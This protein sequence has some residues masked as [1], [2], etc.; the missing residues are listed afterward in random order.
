MRSVH[1]NTRLPIRIPLPGNKTLHLGP[2]KTGQISDQAVETNAV[3]KL[4]RE[5][6]IRIDGEEH[7]TTDAGTDS[8]RSAQE[9]T[10]GH[11]PPTVVT[12]RGNR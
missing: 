2:G 8:R 7:S 5:G 9:S 6:A 12:P 10:H 3:Q 1:N 11:P 4:V